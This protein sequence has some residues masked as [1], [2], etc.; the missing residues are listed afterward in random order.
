MSLTENNLLR[1]PN[2]YHIIFNVDKKSSVG[3]LTPFVPTFNFSNNQIPV[4]NSYSYKEN[5]NDTQVKSNENSNDT[6]VKSNEN[7]NNTQVKS[8]ENSN[9]TQVKPNENSND[10]QVKPNEN[11]DDYT[12]K[13]KKRMEILYQHYGKHRGYFD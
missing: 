6:Q 3:C 10:T 4:Q 11:D 8:N 7:S 5:S 13:A 1:C 9:D 12:I 2:C